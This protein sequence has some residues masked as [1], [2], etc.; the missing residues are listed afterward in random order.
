[1]EAVAALN[2]ALK[3]PLRPPAAASQLLRRS[4]VAGL[5]TVI[6]SAV[7]RSMLALPVH[8]TLPEATL[9]ALAAG[10]ALSLEAGAATVA[11]LWAWA[12]QAGDHQLKYRASASAE[13][14]VHVAGYCA[15]S[16]HSSM[17]PQGWGQAAAPL[18]APP[19]LLELLEAAVPPLLWTK[20][21]CQQRPE[22]AIDSFSW[23]Q[24]MV[25]ALYRDE[26]SS[27]GGLALACRPVL[28]RGLA[29]LV[30]ASLSQLAPMRHMQRNAPYVSAVINGLNTMSLLGYAGD[31][32]APWAGWIA[33]HAAAAVVEIGVQR[34][35]GVDG[36]Q[37]KQL[38]FKATAG[39]LVSSRAYFV[40]AMSP[41]AAVETSRALRVPRPTIDALTQ[42]VALLMVAV[43]EESRFKGVER[44][45]E[46]FANAPAPSI[47]DEGPPA[48]APTEFAT[49]AEVCAALEMAARLLAVLPEVFERL[50]RE[51]QDVSFMGAS[52]QLADQLWTTL[53]YGC[54]SIAYLQLTGDPAAGAAATG[55]LLASVA[56]LQGAASRFWPF[57]VQAQELKASLLMFPGASRLLGKWFH[58]LPPPEGPGGDGPAP[59]F[60]AALIAAVQGMRTVLDLPSI[61]RENESRLLHLVV[62][63]LFH[64][65]CSEAAFVRVVSERGGFALL[66]AQVARVFDPVSALACKLRAQP[67]HAP[68]LMS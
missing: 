66:E 14:H 9:A 68:L 13:Q 22:I 24:E 53:Y 8:L 61:R 54:P 48:A 19:A 52:G 64:D 38:L 2:A 20:Q 5:V 25:R 16:A 65:L 7:V 60:V 39:A 28:Q 50:P 27:A 17:A 12:Q 21:F 57:P 63:L 51:L 47:W 40:A 34:P 31:S 26:A 35:P 1:M 45:L 56:K 33:Q 49:A 43:Q 18:L 4:E 42:V 10:A 58:A 41:G 67:A 59:M 62:G 55:D 15:L 32:A 44:V 29:Q 6:V 11:E 30:A 36:V 46:G 3:Q 23:L 37:H